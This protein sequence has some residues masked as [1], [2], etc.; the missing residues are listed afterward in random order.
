MED[1]GEGLEYMEMILVRHAKAEERSFLGRDFT[2]ALSEEGKLSIQAKL[3]NLEEMMDLTKSYRL[4]SSPALRAIQTAE[5]IANFLDIEVEEE[6]FI[7]D[8]DTSAF[9]EFV[10][11]L[12]QDEHIILVGHQPS[13]SEWAYI[14]S[15]EELAFKV[16]G[17]HALSSD[18]GKQ[19]HLK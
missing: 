17:M 5:Y 8:Q 4:I 14:L 11:Q 15:G 18:D 12:D 2:R 3:V 10:R 6:S 13:L 7:Y 1:C 16:A 9:E 19:F